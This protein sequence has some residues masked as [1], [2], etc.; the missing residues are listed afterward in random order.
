MFYLFFEE[1]IVIVDLLYVYLNVFIV[2]IKSN[3]RV[4][5][6]SKYFFDICLI[7]YLN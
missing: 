4:L 6:N 3:I 2:Y 7:K 1:G 5:S